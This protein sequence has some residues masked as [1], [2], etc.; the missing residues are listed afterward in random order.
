VNPTD[1]GIDITKLAGM[2][3]IWKELVK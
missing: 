2:S 1:P 3:G